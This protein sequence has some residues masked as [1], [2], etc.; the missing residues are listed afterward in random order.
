MNGKPSNSPFTSCKSWA[1]NSTRR[2]PGYHL[3][4]L[5]VTLFGLEYKEYP[6]PGN[7]G[8]LPVSDAISVRI[9]TSETPRA[10]EK[11]RLGVVITTPTLLVVGF[12]PS[13]K[14]ELNPVR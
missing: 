4:I 14:E 2:T 1:N 12:R 8:N 13:N 6:P 9:S 5:F 7:L 11:D 3:R 10:D